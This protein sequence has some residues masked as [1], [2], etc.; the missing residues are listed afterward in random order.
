MAIDK[1]QA[2]GRNNDGTCQSDGDCDGRLV[3]DTERT[4]RSLKEQG[5]DGADGNPVHLVGIHT[6]N[7]VQLVDRIE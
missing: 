1:L 2:V 3:R 7:V 4:L 5:Q 6:A